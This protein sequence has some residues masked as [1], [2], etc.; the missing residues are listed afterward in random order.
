MAE[1]ALIGA[2]L[3]LAIALA[4]RRTHS[5][6]SSGAAA[7]IAV[8]TL[9]VAAGWTWAAV[10]IVYF[11]SSSALSH[12]GRAEKEQRTSRVAAKGGERDAAQVLA[13]GGGFA[14]GALLMLL[15]PDVRWLALGIGSLAA[16]AADTWATEI[17]TLYGGAPRSILTFESLAPGLS[18]G[19]TPLGTLASAVGA[20]FVA[21][22]ACAMGVASRTGVAIAVGGFGGAIIDSILGA[23][24]QARRWCPVCQR[25]T[26]RVVHDCG[27]RTVA[28]SGIA[29]LNNDGVNLVSGILG[30][31]MAAW[32]AR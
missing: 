12:L 18:G 17:G 22:V 29:W 21:I 19:V 8:G 1:R 5:L 24:V 20:C 16:S 7:A 26:E 13:N 15:R 32:M 11:A 9:A 6:S 10:L 28:R 23:S 25:V 2:V 27:T 31:L 30:G 14:I 3:A 4:A